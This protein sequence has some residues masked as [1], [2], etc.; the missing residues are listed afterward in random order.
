MTAKNFQRDPEL[1][2]LI[3]RN[4]SQQCNFIYQQ[5]VPSGIP[6]EWN[7]CTFAYKNCEYTFSHSE[8]RAGTPPFAL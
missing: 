5:V 7:N 1:D 3:L 2:R 4:C 8:F 6:D